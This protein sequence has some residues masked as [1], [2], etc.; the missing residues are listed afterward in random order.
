MDPVPEVLTLQET[1]LRCYYE[2]EILSLASSVDVT[3][4]I[5]V[6]GAPELI[7][8]DSEVAL[9]VLKL[10]INAPLIATAL[11]PETFISQAPKVTAVLEKPLNVASF[12]TLVKSVTE[13]ASHAPSH[14]PVPTIA[15]MKQGPCVCDLYLKLSEKNFVK[16]LHKGDLFSENDH[17]K[18]SEKG[19]YELF[20]R[21]EDTKDYLSF[22]EKKLS[23]PGHGVDDVTFAIENL[24]ALEQI[25]KHM[26]WSPEI[27]LSAQKSVSQAIKILSKN[28]NVMK[29]L[30]KRLSE[31]STSYSRHIGLLSYLV[32]AFS[33]SVGFTGESGQVKLALAALIHDASVDDFYYED[34]KEW[35]KRAADPADKSPET[36]KYRMHPFEASKIVKSLDSHSPDVDQ[37]ILQ[38]HEVKTGQG[39]PR[40]L[41][42]HRIGQLPALFIMVEDLVE[43]IDNGENIET[44][45]VDFITWGSAYYDSGH[46]K[47]IFQAF[48]ENLKQL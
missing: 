17:N 38:H 9:E 29:V 21:I 43:F 16:L 40:G 2:G 36:I 35:N 26:N 48:Q 7:I 45:I 34:L 32:C 20:I 8:A 47:K 12:N 15:L 3:E 19:V 27:L 24:E 5:K 14:V 1:A 30:K 44:S 39:F 23:G 31:S 22:L 46:F 11:K 18:L 41:D 10:N 42:G 6:K 4:M 37:I 33:S 13:Q 25:G 28:Q